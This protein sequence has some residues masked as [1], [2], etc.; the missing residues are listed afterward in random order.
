[1]WSK[2]ESNR[3]LNA[4][5]TGYYVTANPSWLEA[6]GISEFQDIDL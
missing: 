5:R 6:F 1:L 4:L 2:T 3:P